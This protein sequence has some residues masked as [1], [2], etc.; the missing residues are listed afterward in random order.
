M[1]YETIKNDHGLPHNPFKALIVPRPIG[2]IS[3]VNKTGD[4]NLAPYSYFNAFCTRP[5][6][7][8]FGSES[9][10]DSIE[11]IEETGEFVCNLATEEFKEQVNATSDTLPRG[12]SEFAWAG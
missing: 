5:P 7:V 2:W 1:F 4:V 8:G 3:S 12:E 11:F 10:K 9:R 6:I